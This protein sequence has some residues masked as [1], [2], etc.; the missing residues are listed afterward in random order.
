[1]KLVGAR[2]ARDR[3]AARSPAGSGLL[4]SNCFAVY[5]ECTTRRKP[6]ASAGCTVATRSLGDG[7]EEEEEEEEKLT[8]PVV[9]GSLS[10]LPWS[11]VNVP[12]L[13][14]SAA[15]TLSLRSAPRVGVQGLDRFAWKGHPTT[16]SR[17]AHARVVLHT[18]PRDCSCPLH[19]QLAAAEKYTR[20]RVERTVAAP[21][22]C[23]SV[24][25]PVMAAAC[26]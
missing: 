22:P 4:A 6:S 10:C 9:G 16:P 5:R 2:A 14:A 7:E 19:Q 12:C 1:L 21:A 17:H 11:N 18:P 24:V 13:P 23:V 8:L 26:V 25:R 15:L 20:M 3:H